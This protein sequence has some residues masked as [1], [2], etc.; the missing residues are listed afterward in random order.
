MKVKDI[1]FELA[2]AICRKTRKKYDDGEETCKNCP[3]YIPNLYICFK[4]IA[5]LNEKY[6]NK[7]VEL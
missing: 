4:S 1:H 6:G 5:Y 3:L 7:E 2:E